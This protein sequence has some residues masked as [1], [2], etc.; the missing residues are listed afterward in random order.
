MTEERN[1]IERLLR[2]PLT[3]NLTGLP[4]RQLFIDRIQSML[5][6][7]HDQN[8]IQP[9]VLSIGID[10]FKSVND[11]LGIAAGDNILIVLT[12]RLRRLLKTQDTLSRISGDRFGI[13]L[14]SETETQKVADFADAILRSI[15]TH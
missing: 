15:S 1:S 9:T 12:R 8:P 11:R 14:V 6:I 3:D 7:A 2:D 10:G 5:A 4:N 13:V